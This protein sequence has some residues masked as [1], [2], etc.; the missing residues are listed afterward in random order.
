MIL[1]LGNSFIVKVT[2]IINE[3]SY[4][5]QQSKSH[6]LSVQYSNPRM[7]KPINIDID[8]N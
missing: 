5:E 1:K 4:T 8:K 7:N 6:F 2:N 3:M